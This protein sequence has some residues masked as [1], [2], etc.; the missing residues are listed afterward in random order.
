MIKYSTLKPRILLHSC[1]ATCTAHPI[2]LLKERY[3]ISLFYYN[4]NIFPKEEYNRRL[5]D[6]IMLADTAGTKLIKG[7][8]N[9]S[10]WNN[11]TMHFPDEPE[12]GRRCSI[13]FNFRL[14]KTAETAKEAGFD[15]FGTTL[16]ISPHKNYK[17]IN[18]AGEHYS[19][20]TGIDFLKI[21]FKKKDGF[22]KAM[23]LSKKHS[24]YRQNYCGCEYSVR[25]NK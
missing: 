11:A 20:K 4:P 25:S 13:C 1:C 6:I 15:V 22:K 12:G 2:E 7:E 23:D 8:Y 24:F 19:L 21:D 10:G 5:A 14:K 17:I 9:T 16:S 18:E 3:G